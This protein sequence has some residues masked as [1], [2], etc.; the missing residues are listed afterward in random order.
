MSD[1]PVFRRDKYGHAVDAYPSEADHGQLLGINVSGNVAYAT[2]DTVTLA[3]LGIDG[4]LRVPPPERGLPSDFPL[5]E[6]ELTPGEYILYIADEAQPW[7]A[8]SEHGQNLVEETSHDTG[9]VL[10]DG[11]VDADL[12]SLLAALDGATADDDVGEHSGMVRRVAM[13][14]PEQVVDS[15]GALVDLLAAHLGDGETS[16]D[17]AEAWDRAAAAVDL[18]YAVSRA[19]R[20]DPAAVAAYLD[21]LVEMLGHERTAAD[22]PTPRHLTDALDA[23]GRA[24]TDEVAAALA[25]AIEGEADTAETALNALYRLEHRYS[26]DEHPLCEVPTVREAVDD[27]TDREDAV[28]EAALDVGMIHGFHE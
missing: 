17:S 13:D 10:T 19:A 11:P 20:E 2:D 22:Q 12:D 6:V 1:T 25:R 26:A 16:G 5:N 4:S 3:V 28:G 24:E 8:L 21:G 9:V 27:V 15:L 23:I 7:R 18:A 14:H